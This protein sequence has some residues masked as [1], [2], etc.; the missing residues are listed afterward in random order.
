MNT[1]PGNPFRSAA[2]HAAPCQACGAANG[3]TYDGDGR[4][5][6]R[7]CHASVAIAT[8]NA[9]IARSLIVSGYAALVAGVLC[10]VLAIPI[11]LAGHS[12]RG[13][14]GRLFGIA[15]AITTAAGIRMLREGRRR[16]LE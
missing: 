13:G 7:R 3:D 15:G 6:C 2:P 10:I 14:I 4:L 11:G 9:T 8:G 1:P 5:L 16:K 12:R